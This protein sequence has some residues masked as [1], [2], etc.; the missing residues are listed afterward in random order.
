[1]KG[2]EYLLVPNEGLSDDF[3][4]VVEWLE[5]NGAQVQAE[6]PIVEVETSKSVHVLDAHREGFLTQ[7][8]KEGARVRVGRPI[9]MI[10]DDERARPELDIEETEA[11]LVSK[12]AARLME[13][14]GLTVDDFEGLASVRVQDVLKLA[15]R[16][17][18]QQP[19][20]RTFAGEP[21]EPDAD[22]DAVLA[23]EDY[24]DFRALATDLRRR[25]KS[26]HHRHV[27]TGTL[28]Y[29]R[30]DLAQD[31]GFGEGSSVY[32]E[33]LILGDVAIGRHCWIGPFTILDGAWAPL[34]IGDHSSIGSGCQIYTHNTI[35]RTL[36]GNVAEAYRRPTTIGRCCFIS[37]M[38]VIGPGTVMGDHCFVASASFVQG[39]FPP[40]SYIAGAPAKVVGSV[41]VKDGRAKLRL[42]PSTTR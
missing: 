12:K 25:M 29:D 16:Q 15:R 27:P 20:Q 30:W 32:D 14:H 1:M 7:L 5:E 26:R 18:D 42:D 21:L 3:V 31:Y 8:V 2:K 23:R 13:E 39:E 36:T 24:R 17:G 37:P 19:S 4:E 10:T 35:E 22:W 40:S 38:S 6:T 34:S 9:A 33:C 11:P 28:L 41:E